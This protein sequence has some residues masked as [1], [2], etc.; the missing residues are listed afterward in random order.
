MEN[1]KIKIDD[2]EYTTEM[3]A[4]YLLSKDKGIPHEG[5]VIK[6]FLP[7]LIGK[8]K[9]KPKKKIKAGDTILIL[10]AMKMLNLITLKEDIV[11]KEVLVKEGESVSKDQVL[12]VYEPVVK[13]KTK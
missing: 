4:K 6:A 12:V 11:I 5:H 2:V 1:G 13:K 3:T 7:G 9:I 8:V 10:E